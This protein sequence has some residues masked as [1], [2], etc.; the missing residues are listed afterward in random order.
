MNSL[1]TDIIVSQFW[2]L[3]ILSIYIGLIPALIAN[4]KGKV[5]WTWWL[6]GTLVFP[7]ALTMAI[8]LEKEE[9]YN[10]ASERTKT[11]PYCD[12]KIRYKAVVC[13]Y[14]GRDLEINKA[15]KIKTEITNTESKSTEKKEITTSKLSRHYLDIKV[16]PSCSKTNTIFAE[17][18]IVCGTKLQ[19]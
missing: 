12:E 10:I 19:D 15:E 3:I 1:I 17:S 6:A 7:I 16:C 8:L 5:F 4:H 9:Q 11:C 14:C 2:Y 13:M 18:C